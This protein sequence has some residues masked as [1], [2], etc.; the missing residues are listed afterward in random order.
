M[1]M[2]VIILSVIACLE[3]FGLIGVVIAVPIAVLILELVYD[4]GSTEQD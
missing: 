2:L 3:L 1:P 4:H